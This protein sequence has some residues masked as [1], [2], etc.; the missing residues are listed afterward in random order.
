MT[1]PFEFRAESVRW[2]EEL[3]LVVRKDGSL[4][5]L[6]VLV[7]K[8]RETRECV[9][10]DLPAADARRLRDWLCARY[11]ETDTGETK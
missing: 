3:K 1:A 4:G 2:T 9:P 6:P 7:D 8:R 10:I 5:V 11:P